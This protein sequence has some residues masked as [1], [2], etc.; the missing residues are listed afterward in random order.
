MSWTGRTRHIERPPIAAINRL[1]AQLA[2][3]GHDLINLGQAV[4]G[5]PPPPAAIAAVERYVADNRVHTYSPDPGLPEVLESVCGFLQDWKGV[6]ARPPEVMLTCGANQ[7]YANAVFTLS[8]PG[9]EIVLFSPYYFDHLFT[10]KLAGCKPV[11][12][13]C[14]DERQRLVP[15]LDAFE[16]ALTPKTRIVTLVAPA[17]PGGAVLSEDELLRLCR[18]CHQRGIWLISDETYDLLTFPPSRHTSPAAL[19]EHDRIVVLGSFSKTFALASWRI[20]YMWGP[21]TLQEEAVKVQD[22]L[23]VCAP[24]ASQWAVHGALKDVE[25]FRGPAVEE[26]T[27]RR[28]SLLSGL[29]DIPGLPPFLPDGATFILTQIPASLSSVDFATDLLTATGIISVPGAAFGEASRN[30]VRFSFGN[31]EVPRLQEAIKRLKG[32]MLR[33]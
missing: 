14:T 8:N 20:G 2:A 31:Q 22:A 16:R 27:Q 29:L 26:L 24:V 23:V 30:M 6:A 11:I 19:H 32:H 7:A 3:D 12:V 9:D 33:A 1:A 5:L 15:D 21:E 18:I 10:I 17:N 13:C 28:D 4:L 25:S